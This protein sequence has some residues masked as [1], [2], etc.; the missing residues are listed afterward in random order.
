MDDDEPSLEQVKVKSMYAVSLD[1][2][3]DKINHFICEEVEDCQVIDVNFKVI[4]EE[5]AGGR[6][7]YFAMIMYV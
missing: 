1:K 3:D 7:H 4:M 2:L 6:M 5:G